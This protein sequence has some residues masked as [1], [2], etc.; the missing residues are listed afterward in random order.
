MH[1]PLIIRKTEENIQEK[2]RE[3]GVWKTKSM[4]VKLTRFLRY[5]KNFVKNFGLEVCKTISLPGAKPY[6]L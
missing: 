3:K 2:V 5:K 4:N 1:K 6:E